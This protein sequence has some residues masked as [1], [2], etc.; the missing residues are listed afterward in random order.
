MH[1]SQHMQPRHPATQPRCQQST[2]NIYNE[3]NSFIRGPSD[4]STNARPWRSNASTFK[5]SQASSRPG[6][7]DPSPS[8]KSS[9]SRPLISVHSNDEELHRSNRVLN[10]LRIK[11]ELIQKE[12][13]RIKMG[14]TC[15]IS[16]GFSPTGGAG[17]ISGVRRVSPT[18]PLQSMAQSRQHQTARNVYLK[19]RPVE[20]IQRSANAT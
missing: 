13:E 20:Q 3:G 7:V 1:Q 10:E 11:N 19:E 14:E 2:S 9:A 5:P 6:P 17:S 12:I 16:G 4:V 15:V 8:S 18:K